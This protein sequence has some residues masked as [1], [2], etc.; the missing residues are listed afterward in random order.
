MVTTKRIFGLDILR[1]VAILLVLLSHSKAL[2]YQFAPKE[3]I[4]FYFKNIG[5]IGVEIFFILSGF[6]I[7]TILI[8]TFYIEKGNIVKKVYNFW[9][10]RWFRTLP[11]Y[12]F[13][14]GV[15][16]LFYFYFRNITFFDYS[17]L[18]FMQNFASHAKIPFQ[19]SWSLTIEEWFY[20][21]LPIIFVTIFSLKIFTAK[22]KILFAII[23][24]IVFFASFR[25]YELYS[26]NH[27]SFSAVNKI[28]LYRLDSL[29]YGV[30][31]AYV[32]FFYKNILQKYKYILFEI[33]IIL[34]CT[35]YISMLLGL[36][37]NTFVVAMFFYPVL[38]ISIMLLVPFFYFY[39][40]SANIRFSKI[41]VSH[42][43]KVSYSMYLSNLI[44]LYFFLTYLQHTTVSKSFGF[45]L[46]ISFFLCVVMISSIT[47]FVIEK[48]F[49]NLRKYFL[50]REKAT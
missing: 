32:I 39:K 2:M 23:F 30:L 41:L 31:M 26:S 5:M 15:N 34:F 16:V 35:I 28:V 38:D 18:F 42:I 50:I 13:F 14:L 27:I 36:K 8:K 4:D 11:N 3:T 33:G 24:T 7:G 47:Y 6:L 40:E 10:K 43:A 19:E 45:I 25:F 29:I 44:V 12:Y 17:Y 9:I 1:A 49:I 20:I 21:L 46:W 37:F 22:S 48:R